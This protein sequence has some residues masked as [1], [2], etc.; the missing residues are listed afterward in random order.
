MKK[1][2]LCVAVAGILLVGGL[3][4]GALLQGPTDAPAAPV[5]ESQISWPW[6]PTS[7]QCFNCCINS[8]CWQGP[9]IALCDFEREAAPVGLFAEPGGQC[10]AMAPPIGG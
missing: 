2:A 6:P 1:T 5:P 8:V 4:G 9:Y 3:V 7:C 10:A